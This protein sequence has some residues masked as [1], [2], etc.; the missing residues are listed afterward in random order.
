MTDKGAG[1]TEVYRLVRI[2]EESSLRFGQEHLSE[3][4]QSLAQGADEFISTLLQVGA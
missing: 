4:Q 2:M 1:R 3:A